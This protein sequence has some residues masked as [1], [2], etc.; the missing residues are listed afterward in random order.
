MRRFLGGLVATLLLVVLVRATLVWIP[1]QRMQRAV[2]SGSVAIDQRDHRWVLAPRAES[3]PGDPDSLHVEMFLR[4]IS[5]SLVE[6]TFLIKID[7]DARSVDRSYMELVVDQ[8]GAEVLR[9]EIRHLNKEREEA[10]WMCKEVAML[11]YLEAK[12][13]GSPLTRPRIECESRRDVAYGFT[14]RVPGRLEPGEVKRF[15]VEE[16]LPARYSGR[17]PTLT[18]AGLD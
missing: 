16:I 18:V 9:K 6:G 4:N 1:F 10:E 8:Y 13:A 17:S 2:E 12:E 5:N 7:L 14:A 3:W 11:R 15:V